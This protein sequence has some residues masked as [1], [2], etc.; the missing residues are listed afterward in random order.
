MAGNAREAALL[1]LERCRRDGAWSGAV[2]DALIRSQ[3]LDR[4]DAALASQLCLG[5]LQNSVWLDHVIDAYSRGKLEPK[6]RD[7]LRLGAYQLLFLDKIPKRAAVNE[8]VSLCRA[9]GYGRA[10]GLVNAV[11]RRISENDPPPISETD[12]AKRLSI[13]WSHPEWLVRRLLRDHDEAFVE[14]FLRCN[15]DIPPLTL[16]VNRLKVEPRDYERALERIGIDFES[17][18]ELPGCLTLTSGAVRELPGFEEGLFYVQD[19]AAR[20]AVA[21]AG[22]KPGMRVL[23]ACAAP[24]G[25]SFAAAMELENRG[26]ILSCDL[27]EKKLGRIRSGAERLGITILQTQARDGR[28]PDDRELGSFDAVLADVPCSGLGVIRKRPE[29]RQKTEEE[30]RELPSIQA[31]ILEHLAPLVKSGGLLLYST[32]TV[33]PEENEE[34]IRSFLASHPVFHA[35][36]FSLGRRQIPEGML[37]F[38][39]QI[40][41]TD[42]FFVCKLRKS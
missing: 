29:I 11:L 40:D 12:P 34:Q 27:H 15:N 42:G 1:A 26:E 10:S 17:D 32:C 3:D 20:S 36:G 31:E 35:E 22:L 4:R 41:G 13:R 33:L 19:R 9:A 5:V 25:K 37:T 8:T 39:P 18:P 23:D 28:A 21:A 7:V 6:L 30:L 2:L 14:G 16:Q 38:W 24:G